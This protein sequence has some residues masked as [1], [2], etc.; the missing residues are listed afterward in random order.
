MTLNF[1]STIELTQAE[2]YAILSPKE[3][4]EKYVDAVVGTTSKILCPFHKDTQPSMSFYL[5][6]ELKYK[7]F[8]CGVQGNSINFVKDLFG[9]NYPAALRKI[10][11]DFRLTSSS[12]PVAVTRVEQKVITQKETDTVIIPVLKSFTMVDH[13]YWARFHIELSMLV[14]YDVSAC[15]RVYIYRHGIH[16]QAMEYSKH[17]PV[18]CYS[19]N[20]KYKIYRPLNIDGHKWLNTTTSGD[21]QG[22]NQLPEQGSLVILT[23]SLKDVMVLK[24]LGYDAIALESEGARMNMKVLDYLSAT[25]EKVVIFY[26]NDAPGIKYASELSKKLNIPYIY[27][28]PYYPEKDISDL[29]AKRGLET[30]TKLMTYLLDSTTT[31]Q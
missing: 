30:A 11:Q 16:R 21:V 18:Y 10:T 19:I 17:D 1:D 13:D 7:C 4:Y 12:H 24:V 26:D 31:H 14:T 27:I 9:L 20:D 29:A 15:E 25:F 3:I 22:M 6:D 5:T 23:S 28:P 8:A 2:I